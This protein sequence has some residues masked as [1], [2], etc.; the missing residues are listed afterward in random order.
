MEPFSITT[1]LSVKDHAKVMLIGLYKKPSFIVIALFGF[2]FDA[3]L[4]LDYL[5]YIIYETTNWYLDLFYGIFFPLFPLLITIMV[6]IQG[7]SNET[8]RSAMKYT[9]DEN[10][11]TAEGA[12]CKSE[13]LWPYFIKKREINHFILL[14]HTQKFGSYIDKRMLTPEQ[15]EF[16]KSRIKKK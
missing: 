1:R 15:L 5:G 12:N 16:I 11:M 8:L 9:F 6:V 3:L 7:N 10:G 13:Y 2:Y 4:L 14:Y